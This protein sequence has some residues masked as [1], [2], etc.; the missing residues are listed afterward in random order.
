M[1]YHQ[2][3]HLTSHTMPG[4]RAQEREGWRM[5]CVARFIALSGISAG[6]AFFM[7][8]CRGSSGTPQNETQ[9]PQIK[10]KPHVV[11]TTVEN[12]IAM[13]DAD[14]EDAVVV[15]V[16]RDEQVFLGSDRTNL[17]DLSPRVRGMLAG[18]IIKEG[19]IRADARTKLRAV[20][21]VIDAL[22][23]ADVDDVGLLVSSKNA[24]AQQNNNEF[25]KN[26]RGLDLVVLS[27]SVMKEHFPRGITK[28]LDR[29]QILR[30]PT[31]APAYK[32]NQTGV[33]KAE[34]LPK[35]TEM[36]KSRGERILFIRGDDDL[37]FAAVVEVIDIA[38]RADVDHVALLTPQR[39]AGH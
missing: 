25:Q 33:Q 13:P 24:D 1:R 16:A 36:Y 39:L 19:F 30:V 28:S 22:S 21:D 35:L 11:M 6:L 4:I 23:A 31:G 32:I 12:A 37:D 15:T 14:K 20:E 3:R 10:W 17:S 8:G 5:N 34:L 29:V 18:K 9:Q 38:K 27:P 7:C 2:L 26:L